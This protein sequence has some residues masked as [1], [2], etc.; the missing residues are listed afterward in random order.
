MI[1]SLHADFTAYSSMRDIRPA[2][3]VPHPT[4]AEQ[5][6]GNLKTALSV[7]PTERAELPSAHYP[8]NSSE[9]LD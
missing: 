1:Y 3:A 2:F 8:A 7:L 4:N 5:E 9:F 6:N